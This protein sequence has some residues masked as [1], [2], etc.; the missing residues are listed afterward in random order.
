M[1]PL[2]ICDLYDIEVEDVN[3]YITSCGIVSKNCFDEVTDFLESQFRF[4]I[5]WNR[6]NDPRQRCR[7][8]CTCNPPSTAE[9][10]WIVS[11]WAP[12]LDPNHPNP[13]LPGELRWYTTNEKGEDVE[14]PSGDEIEI[15]GEMVKPRSRTFIPSS[16]DDNPYLAATSYKSN[17]QSLPEPLRSQM[18]KG[19]FMAGK[20][21]N[22]WQVIPT[23]WVE[24]AQARWTETKPRG[25]KMSA[26]GVDPARG[27]RDQTILA[28]RYEWWYSELIVQDG[29]TTPSGPDVAAL[30]IGNVRDGAPIFIDVIG[31]AGT[32]PYDHMKGQSINVHAVDGRKESGGREM[33]GKFGFV[34][35]RSEMWWR[36]REALD[37]DHGENIALP[38]DRKLL[39]DLCT[40]RWTVTPRGIQVEPK[41]TEKEGTGIIKRL[42]RSPDRGDAVVYAWLQADRRGARQHQRPIRTKS[43]YSPHNWRRTRGR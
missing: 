19:D 30:C 27:G 8:I 5:T 6:S 13:A 40:P 2:G 42:G 21:D 37:P 24:A 35:M 11:Y 1:T 14:C 33:S 41:G 43:N 22:A 9:G 31:G 26:L 16:V 34:N 39:A 3:H 7:V 10:A 32:S 36:F 20:E 17:L 25:L 15:N 18:L 12:W 28:P 29:A 38:P 23:A 4:V